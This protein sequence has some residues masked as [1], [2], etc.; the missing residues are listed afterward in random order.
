MKSRGRW[1]PPVS[2]ATQALHAVL[3]PRD[4]RRCAGP[5]SLGSRIATSFS[6]SRRSFAGLAPLAAVALT[7]VLLARTPRAAAETPGTADRLPGTAALTQTEELI[8][9]ILAGTSRFLDRKLAEAIE[10]RQ[11]LWTRLMTS[12]AAQRDARLVEL[13]GRLEQIL[14]AES[15]ARVP[16]SAPTVVTPLGAEPHLARLEG[17]CRVRQI[18]WPVVDGYTAEGLIVEPDGRE[19]QATVI[20]LADAGT[21]IEA[22][23]GLTAS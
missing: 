9:R 1:R 14:G 18:R 22:L 5:E 17:I 19:P 23:T 12:P 4:S 7:A 20:L 2:V 11:Q 16:G 13:R 15:D 3:L 6:E 10:Q 8:D 21:S